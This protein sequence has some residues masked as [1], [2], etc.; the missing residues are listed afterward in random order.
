[1]GSTLPNHPEVLKGL[2]Y[3]NVML[4]SMPDGFAALG[5][6]LGRYLPFNS[7]EIEFV[8]TPLNLPPYLPII[9]KQD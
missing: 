1:M 6:P 5:L 7:D 2:S 4:G 9:L 8:T 3:G